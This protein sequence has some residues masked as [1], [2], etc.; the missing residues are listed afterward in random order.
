MSK[1]D[2]A[3][4]VGVLVVTVL[5]GIFLTVA[6]LPSG[7]SKGLETWSQVLSAI[8]ALAAAVVALWLGLDGHRRLERIDADRAKLAAAKIWHQVDLLAGQ[9]TSAR[10][11]FVFSGT[12]SGVTAIWTLIPRAK[13]L[14]AELKDE[15]F[16]ALMP[17]GGHLGTRLA[18]TVSRLRSFIS[19]LDGRPSDR[20]FAKDE[21]ISAREELGEIEMALLVIGRTL[22]VIAAGAAP[23]PTNEEVFGPPTDDDPDA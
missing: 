18:A 16:L 14:L 20:H 5:V 13:P 21:L 2:R 17:L 12:G 8:G 4:V 7:S 23:Q 22:K 15:D 11:Q 6:L 10:A 1:M 19:R 9:V 3:F